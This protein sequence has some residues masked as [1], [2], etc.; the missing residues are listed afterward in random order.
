[1]MR[2]RSSPSRGTSLFHRVWRR[3]DGNVSV[4]FTL[5]AMP[6]IGAIGLGVDITRAIN[7]KAALQASV[8]TAAI[9]GVAAAFGPAAQT[10]AVTDSS[11][12]VGRSFYKDAGL[13]PFNGVTPATQA[14]TVTGAAPGT[15]TVK[16]TATA[17]I[18]PAFL[19]YL[20]S[21]VPV[22]ATATAVASSPSAASGLFPF[23]IPQCTFDDNW[24]AATGQPNLDSH[25]N[26]NHLTLDGSNQSTTKNTNCTFGQWSSLTVGGNSASEVDGFINGGCP[27]TV[28]IGDQIDIQPGTRASLYHAVQAEVD[29]A[30]AAGLPGVTVLMAVVQGPGL[31]TNAESQVIGFAP[32]LITGTTNH[33]ISGNFVANF[34]A[35]GTSIGASSSVAA[36]NFGAVTIALTQ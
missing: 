23:A 4:L 14:I 8:D 20:A 5:L 25:G 6:M 26:P 24:N 19:L 30:T 11:T 3:T 35:P 18:Q 33:S 16:A 22:S 31:N 29:A 10:G 13:P 2:F 7:M 21:L 27:C 1:M 36:P 17:Q 9:S 32:F 28:A 15:V 34:H 12:A